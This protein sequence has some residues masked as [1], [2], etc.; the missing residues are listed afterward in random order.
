M[1]SYKNLLP[2]DPGPWFYARANTREEFGTI[3][4]GRVAVS[5]GDDR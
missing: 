1:P 4:K 2:G 3:L 5:G